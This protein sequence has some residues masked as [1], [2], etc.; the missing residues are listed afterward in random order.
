MSGLADELLADLDGLSDGG[1]EN[2]EEQE[3]PNLTS[4]SSGGLKRK[5]ED[6]GSDDGMSDNEEQEGRADQQDVGSL[7]LDGGVKPAEE[8]DAEE[9]Q[10]MELGAIADV[11]KVAKL[12]G[13]K[14]MV[15]ILKVRFV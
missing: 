11:S 12:E 13:S 2:Q 1:E 7:V 8:L 9:V 14:K 4:S 15:D 5:R 6:L 10:R 3:V